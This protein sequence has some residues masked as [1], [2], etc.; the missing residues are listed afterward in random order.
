M[1]TLIAVITPVNQ[2]ITLPTNKAT[3]EG[4]SSKDDDDALELTYQWDI[5]EKPNGYSH[6]GQ[7]TDP[8]LMLDNLIA[9]NYTVRL[10]VEDTKGMYV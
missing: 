5:R 7:S 4:S 8:T 3:L 9:G 2:T 6:E 10:T 1:N